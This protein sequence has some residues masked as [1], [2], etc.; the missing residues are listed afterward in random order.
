M[1]EKQFRGERGEENQ[2]R[3]PG[4]KLMTVYAKMLRVELHT[5]CGTVGVTTVLAVYL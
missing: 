4:L 3:V 1:G 5:T 2:V